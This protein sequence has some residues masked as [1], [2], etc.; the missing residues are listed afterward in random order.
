MI[1][2]TRAYFH[3]R[4]AIE[5][6]EIAKAMRAIA[7]AKRPL[8]KPALAKLMEDPFLASVLTTTCVA[9]MLS[10]GTKVNALPPEARANINCRFLPDESV[11][12]VKSR[13]EKIIQDPSIEIIEES[14]FGATD[15]KHLRKNGIN[16]YGF[17]TMTG[18]EKDATRAHGIDERIP[19]SSIR[20]GLELLHQLVLKLAAPY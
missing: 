20:P 4:A 15:S 6:P 3:E 11:E 5:K 2:V 17:L 16:S 7:D 9:T 12:V 13:L 1:P 14:K 19:V 8:P 10:G 18:F